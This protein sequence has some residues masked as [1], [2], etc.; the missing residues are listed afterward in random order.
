MEYK[1]LSYEHFG[2]TYYFKY[3][4]NWF[5]HDR[6]LHKQKLLNFDVK[7]LRDHYLIADQAYDNN[8]WTMGACFKMGNS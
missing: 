7:K 1:K 6:N 3:R 4:K 8:A 5:D 2:K